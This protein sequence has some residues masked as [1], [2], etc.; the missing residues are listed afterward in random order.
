M[1]NL[2]KTEVGLPALSRGGGGGATGGVQVDETIEYRKLRQFKINGTVGEPGQKNCV[3]YS[4][5]C[6]QIKQGESQGY[7]ISEIYHGIIKAIEAGNPLRDMLELEA[8]D[9]DKRALMTT[10][11][12]HF[13]ERDPNAIFNEL[14]SAT[15]GS[16]E[17][18]QRFCCR[19]VALKKKVMHMS[20][21][22]N[23]AVDE[24]NLRTTFFRSLYTGLRQSSIRNELRQILME[25]TIS[26]DALLSQVSLAT[27]NE[28]ERAR[29][30]AEMGR[31][32]TVNKLTYDSD[33][34]DEFLEPNLSDSSFFSSS[35]NQ[36]NK[37]NSKASRKS[38]KAVQ[39]S[40][41][42]QQKQPQNTKNNQDT[43]SSAD[44][45]K[46]AAA[47]ERLSTANEVLTAEVNELKRMSGNS[48]HVGTSQST[49][50]PRQNTASHNNNNNVGNLQNVF[51]PTTPTLNPTAP[52]FR[53]QVRRNNTNRPIYLC[54][55]CA[56]ANIP[57]CRHC[58]KCGQGDHKIQDCPEN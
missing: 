21:A 19:C 9:F 52:T 11:K 29:K 20:E 35:G 16:N 17:S 12:A 28:E 46:I 45:G 40:R 2:G 18:A 1:K 7:S 27:A 13:M 33:S 24:E 15:Q 5:L 23:I 39:N 37:S 6:Y 22:E 55:S 42:N 25:A 43:L 14:K 30:M 41:Q 3:S 31:K 10:L 54:N 36:Q 8:D 56:A 53:S 50:I 32:V 49:T 44:V 26:D 58:F 4:S 48:A 51:R 38:K 34:P 57:F 47:L